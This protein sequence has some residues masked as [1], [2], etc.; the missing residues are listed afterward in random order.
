VGSVGSSSIGPAGVGAV[1]GGDASTSSNRKAPS[2]TPASFRDAVGSSAA[3]VDS[4][5]GEG[6]VDG[7]A[8]HQARG[9]GRRGS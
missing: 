2:V 7:T 6:A 1:A 9:V 5:A 4:S 8:G 3:A